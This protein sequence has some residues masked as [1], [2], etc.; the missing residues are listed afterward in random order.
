MKKFIIFLCFFLSTFSLLPEEVEFSVQESNSPSIDE[1]YTQYHVNL[2][3][4]KSTFLRF[5]QH[6]RRLKTEIKNHQELQKMADDFTSLKQ[7]APQDKDLKKAIKN[8]ILEQIHEQ[9]SNTPY[10]NLYKKLNGIIKNLITDLHYCNGYLKLCQQKGTDTLDSNKTYLI[11]KYLKKKGQYESL[12]E[13]LAE[14]K[15]FFIKYF[16]SNLLQEQKIMHSPDFYKGMLVGS[17]IP[18]LLGFTA[19]LLFFLL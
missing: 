6:Y 18:G 10:H 5:K 17:G 15:Y 2:R 16:Q 1:L 14:I 9:Q 19:I 3:T 11:Q 4:N 7:K 12:G 13:I 8:F